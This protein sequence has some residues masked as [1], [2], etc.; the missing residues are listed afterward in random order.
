[1]VEGACPQMERCERNI[2]KTGIRN[3][4]GDKYQIDV[5]RVVIF[6]LVLCV[7]TSVSEEPA[8]SMIW[9]YIYM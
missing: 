3:F 7:F 8:A 6:S 2:K 4:Q 5:F 9:V 1:M